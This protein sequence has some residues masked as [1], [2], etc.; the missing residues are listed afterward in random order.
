MSQGRPVSQFHPAG[1]SR[2][3]KHRHLINS[4]TCVGTTEKFLCLI[5]KLG[6]GT[7]ELPGPLPAKKLSKGKVK[8]K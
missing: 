3:F 7:L 1:Y 2:G 8:R 5:S 6:N 4:G